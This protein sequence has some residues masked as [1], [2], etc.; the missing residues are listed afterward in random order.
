MKSLAALLTLTT[1]L[2]SPQIAQARQVSLTTSIANY[3]GPPAYFA[4]YLTKPDGS[5]EKTLWLAGSRSRYLRELSGW[6]RSISASGARSIDGVSG[7]SVGPG[8]TLSVNLDLADSLINAG[9][10]IHVDSAVEH[11]GSYRDEIVMP[12]SSDVAGQPQ[13]GNGFVSSLTV[14]M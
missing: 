6:V 9:Y 12:L 4:I 1:A 5:Y 3:Y 8:Q 13:Q 10:K 7:A 2:V 14:G 11:A